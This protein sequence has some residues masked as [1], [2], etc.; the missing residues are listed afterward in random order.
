[1]MAKI[2]KTINERAGSAL[3]NRIAF[4]EGPNV[5]AIKKNPSEE[6]KHY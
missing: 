1:M 3:V 6:E 5:K 2:I 4:Q